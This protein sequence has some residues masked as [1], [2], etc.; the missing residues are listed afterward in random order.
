MG[1]VIPKRIESSSLAPI[2]FFFSAIFFFLLLN[3]LIIV[4]TSNGVFEFSYIRNFQVLTMVHLAALGWAV[5]VII[6]A[7]HQLVPV[8][9]EVPLYNFKLAEVTFY[10]YFVGVA[11]FVLSLYLVNW[12]LP[13]IIFSLL[14]FLALFLFCI[15][16]ILTVKKVEKINLIGWYLIWALFYF[17][18]TFV[19]G[20]LLALNL[21]FGFFQTNPEIL[22]KA[23][24]HLAVLGFVSLIIM[25]VSYKLIP[26]FALSHGFKET[27]GKINLILMNIGIWLLFFGFLL[28]KKLM[29]TLATIILFLAVVFYLLQIYE[30]LQKRFRKFYEVNLLYSISACFSLFIL[31]AG[32]LLY[33]FGII[34]GDLNFHYAYSYLAFMGWISFYIIGQ[35]HKIIPF[36]VWLNKYSEKVGLQKVPLMKEMVNE[37]LE[38]L[39]F[40]VMNIGVYGTF[41]AFVFNL[42]ILILTA[43]CITFL[44]AILLTCNLVRVL[45]K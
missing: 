24:S 35:L 22:I 4:N 21:H 9:L 29:L 41:L 17:F 12:G 42:K 13:V 44:G 38:K 40:Y 15:N 37:K 31:A 19:F 10:S 11:G 1:I 45:K 25:G 6:G 16:I 2:K 8:V 26:M 28:D 5:M 34:K 7:M 39:E 32:A 14:I 3:I 36:L 23:H 18:A 30:I 27:N 33:V 43:S 20:F